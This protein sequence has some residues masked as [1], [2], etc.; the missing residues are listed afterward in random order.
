[1]SNTQ[2]S[3]FSLKD[4]ENV[5][6][7]KFEKFADK[8]NAHTDQKIDSAIESLAL[9]VGKEFNRIGDQFND[10]YRRFDAIDKRIDGIGNRI[11]NLSTNMDIRFSRL[12]SR[13][14]GVELKTKKHNDHFRG[15][16]SAL[17]QA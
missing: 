16:K 3:A 6:D 17:A 1:M 2:V 12:E 13:F 9:M 7:K 5:M 14:D 15:I 10:V 11:D 4:I 8:I